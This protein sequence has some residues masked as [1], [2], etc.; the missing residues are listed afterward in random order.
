MCLL[1]LGLVRTRS[2]ARRSAGRRPI[3]Q[4]WLNPLPVVVQRHWNEP[5]GSEASA[6]P[7]WRDRW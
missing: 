7:A 2:T 6:L 5:I 3:A 4:P 1:G